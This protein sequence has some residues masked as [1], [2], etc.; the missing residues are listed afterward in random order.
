MNQIEQHIG[1]HDDAMLE[2]CAANDILVQAATPL[3][4]YGRDGRH[5]RDRHCAGVVG[6]GAVV[7][8]VVGGG[9]SECVAIAVQVVVR[10]GTFALSLTGALLR[11]SHLVCLFVGSIPPPPHLHSHA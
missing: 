7:G 6:V 10:L 4:R 8:G 5:L 2:F 11:P 9:G 3:A 1:W